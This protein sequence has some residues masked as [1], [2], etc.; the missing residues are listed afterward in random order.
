MSAADQRYPS[1]RS[2]PSVS[3]GRSAVPAA[4]AGGVALAGPVAVFAAGAGPTSRSTRSP[5]PR[6]E[7]SRS[8]AAAQLLQTVPR[9]FP[10]HLV[11]SS[12]PGSGQDVDE[13]RPHAPV[14]DVQPVVVEVVAE[15]VAGQPLEDG[16][17]RR[18]RAFQSGLGF[19]GQVRGRRRWRLGPVGRKML[20]DNPA[21]WQVAPLDWG[22]DFARRHGRG[23]IA[24]QRRLS[25][26]H[27]VLD[28]AGARRRACR[29]AALGMAWCESCLGVLRV[30]LGGV[31]ETAFGT[32]TGGTIEM[33]VLGA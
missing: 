33:R 25:S 15:L 27:W 21:S 9:E 23:W 24:P 10:Q 26:R 11:E 8:S 7:S 31:D 28:T 30:A 12:L 3:A 14:V 4:V 20:S 5:F 19:F 2:T 29:S 16:A 6:P 1:S 22:G 17:L 32:R 13:L 18:H